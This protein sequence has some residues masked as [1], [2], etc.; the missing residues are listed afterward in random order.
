LFPEEASTAWVRRKKA[1][2]RWTLDPSNGFATLANPGLASEAQQAAVEPAGTY[3]RRLPQ[4]TA[5]IGK[6][7][8]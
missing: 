5:G 7:P 3:S 8:F 4:E 6:L 2:V 1:N